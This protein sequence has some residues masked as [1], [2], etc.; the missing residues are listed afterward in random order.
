MKTL[1]ITFCMALGLAFA[2]PSVSAACPGKDKAAQAGK[3]KAK[4]AKATAGKNRAVP[5]PPKS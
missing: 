2:L 5:Q 1:A 3:S 4:N